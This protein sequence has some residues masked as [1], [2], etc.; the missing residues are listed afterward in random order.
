M[1]R[2]PRLLAAFDDLAPLTIV[3]GPGGSGKSILVAQWA[4][5]RADASIPGLWIT[6]TDAGDRRSFWRSVAQ[7]ARDAG[8]PDRRMVDE[9]VL[10]ALEDGEGLQGGLERLFAGLPGGLV[11][12]LDGFERV[13]DPQVH[14]DLT[15]MLRSA[16]QIRL[17]VSTRA[18]G[19]LESPRRML[20]LDAL[21]V[22]LPGLL[23]TV[24][25]TT[26][27]LEGSLG[28]GRMVAA[29]LHA[30]T[31][32]LPLATQLAA[33]RSRLDPEGFRAARESGG[34]GPWAAAVLRGYLTETE[35]ASD[36]FGFAMRTAVA[37][38]LTAGLA[39]QLSGRADAAA[40]LDAVEREGLGYWETGAEERV[41]RYPLVVRE[42]L[43]TEV[44][45][46]HPDEIERLWR[47]AAAVEL[48]SSRP[49]P[50]LRLALEIGDLGLATKIVRAC[51]NLL[52][53]GHS[54]ELIA[55]LGP[56]PRRRLRK[57]PLLLMVL[58][59]CFN[60]SG[61][62]RMRGI[63]T[64]GLAVVAARLYASDV[65][66]EERVLLLGAETGA[67]RVSGFAER[68]LRSAET[69]MRVVEGMSAESRDELRD[70]LPVAV[71]QV[72]LT[73][74]YAGRL[75]EARRMF[76]AMYSHSKAHA[77]G[78]GSHSLALLA[79][80]HALLGD[81]AEA[82]RLVAEGAVLSWIGERVD[83]TGSLYHL[84]KALLHLESF[85]FAAAQSE[86]AIVVPH[87]P[88]LEHWPLF[89]YV[90]AMI[91]L[92]SGH[93]AAGLLAL[94]SEQLSRR[95][96]IGRFTRMRLD[97]ARAML[98]LAVGRASDAER[99]LAAHP[100]TDPQVASVLAVRELLGNRPREASRLADDALARRPS[101]PRSQLQLLLVDA[102]AALR[103][104]RDETALSR[105]DQ[106]V[107]LMSDR[108]LRFPLM[109]VPRD[110]L[111][112]L[113]TAARAQGMPQASELL[114]DLEVIP[115]VLPSSLP[116][117]SLT[118]RELTVLLHLA[119]GASLLDIAGALFISRNT[120]KTHLR[121][122]YRK[123][124]VGSREEALVEAGSQGLL[125]S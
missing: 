19:P 53:D 121:S 9:E 113:L 118:Q 107:R 32:G 28:E 79:G 59:I 77:P 106:A 48:R 63:E 101:A 14:E 97:S 76:E 11:L 43:L 49:L 122:L 6:V 108:D 23:F 5:S 34:L 62:H 50:A 75:E 7:A 90:Q 52:G 115:S 36:H 61:N 123:L 119:D 51:W 12:V 22:S 20:E 92:G 124:G 39:A 26:E 64:F 86:V 35:R 16:P 70:S 81:M 83:Y 44:R 102:I 10:P 80:H 3:R 65:D 96:S 88:T 33:L 99:L 2:R 1:Q 4:Y 57:H 41:F 29:E 112:A 54:A 40:L 66:V 111:Q 31:G 116:K 30:A 37:E 89:A 104:G 8:L 46:A 71:N 105:L 98:M 87:L 73:F 55:L 117:V 38:R 100:S 13:L 91:D 67:L 84:A 24:E 120:L 68:A 93:A 21:L 114:R 18:L 45:S 103:L 85:D 82:R 95:P 110:D 74:F 58:A 60:A 69:T 56:I 78:V 72:G 47:T 94:D 25:E 27:L 17:V 42:L 109:L 125:E 15:W